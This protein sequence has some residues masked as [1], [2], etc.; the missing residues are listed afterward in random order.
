MTIAD[1]EEYRELKAIVQEVQSLLTD[2]ADRA[3]PTLTTFLHNARSRLT[4]LK[5]KIEI[6]QRQ[7]QEQTRVEMATAAALEAQRETALS[8]NEQ[9]TFAGFLSRTISRKRI[10]IPSISFTARAG[11][12]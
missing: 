3:S 12:D 10:S 8:Q 7:E 1:E 6:E 4:D 11:I 5:Q 9:R 2:S